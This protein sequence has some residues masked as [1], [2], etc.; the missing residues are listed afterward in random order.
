NLIK[1]IFLYNKGVRANLKRWDGKVFKK[2]F[3]ISKWLFLIVFAELALNNSSPSLLASL[4]GTDE[5]AVFAIGFSI[6]SYVSAFAGSINGLFLPQVS[7][8]HI[9]KQNKAIS[10]L[11]IKV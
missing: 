2:I 10:A 7:R 6:A 3:G 1:V 9:E 8:L 11:T 5:I 4:S